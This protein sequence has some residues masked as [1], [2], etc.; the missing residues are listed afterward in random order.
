MSRSENMCQSGQRGQATPP[1]GETVRVIQMHTVSHAHFPL[2]GADFRFRLAPALGALLVVLAAPYWAAASGVTIALRFAPQ[3]G[4]GADVPFEMSGCLE[5]RQ[6]RLVLRDVVSGFTEEVRGK[7][8]ERNIG[9]RVE[10]TAKVVPGVT[11]IEGAQEVIEISRIRRIS[12]KCAPPAPAPVRRR[13]E[14]S[15]PNR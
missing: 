4:T 13:L 9:K 10:V 15:S 12:G 8:L 6:D 2:L 7:R 11:P 14:V 1:D 3:Q 5:R